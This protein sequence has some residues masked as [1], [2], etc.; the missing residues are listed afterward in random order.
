MTARR[1]EASRGTGS[2]RCPALV[3]AG[4]LLAVTFGAGCAGYSDR[5]LQV[6]APLSQ[7]DV[8]AARAFL[9]KE[10]PGGNGLPYLFEL[11]LVQRLQEDFPA[12]NATFDAAELRVDDLYTKSVSKAALAVALNDEVVPYDGEVWERV[13]VNYYRALNYVD[14]DD[15]E[16]ALVECRKINHKLKVYVDS[17]DSPPTYRTDAFAEYMTAMLYEA[18]GQTNDAWVS[19]RLADEAYAHYEEA[20][21]VKA[22]PFLAQDLLRLAEAQGY[23][24]EL[25]RYQERFPDAKWTANRELL[26]KGEIVLFYEEGFAPPK[27]QEA[28]TLPILKSEYDDGN[29]EDFS[30]RLSDRARRRD[31]AYKKT[32]LEYLLRIAIP[33]FATRTVGEMPGHAV[34]RAGDTECRSEIAEDI[35][36]IARAGLDD[37][38]GKI[39]FKTIL[40]ALGKYALTRGVEKKQGE[41]VGLLAN[42]LTAAT[43]KADTRS[44]ITLP[45]TIQIARLV[46]EPGTHDVAID[47]HGPGGGTFDSVTFEDVE[48]GAGEVRFLWHR[49][50]TRP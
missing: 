38:M 48:V 34:L 20:Y 2:A 16:G 29:R 24:D 32:E 30:R 17:D 31:F 43:E 26:E 36:A 22:P 19:L 46:V 15:Y 35:S 3:A 14:L 9:E 11:G 27:V 45:N 40:R 21:G 42:L 6:R 8:A 4:F 10:K 18:G 41:V 5:A 49:T 28:L 23:T 44:W 47:C 13:L 37:E 7:G 1:R 39:L 50:F 33:T 25:R 12:S